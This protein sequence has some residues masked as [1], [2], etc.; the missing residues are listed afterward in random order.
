M[1]ELLLCEEKHMALW[2]GRGGERE[3]PSVLGDLGLFW[4][5]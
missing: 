4:E 3:L 2:P 1:R 5:I